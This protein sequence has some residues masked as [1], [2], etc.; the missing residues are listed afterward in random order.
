LLLR[1]AQKRKMREKRQGTMTTVTIVCRHAILI[2][3]FRAL[4]AD[5]D[6]FQFDACPDLDEFRTRDPDQSP[7][8]L[9]IDTQSGIALDA[10]SELIFRTPTSRVLLWTD[11]VAPQ[12]GAQAI[13]IGVCG[14][15]LKDAPVEDYRAC[16]CRVSAGG[17]W[18]DRVLSEQMHLMKAVRLT[19]CERQLVG[20][21][22][23]GLSNK[24]IACHM[25]ITEGT[26]KIYLR[27]LYEQTGTGDRFGL[28][29]FALRNLSIGHPRMAASA[30][31]RNASTGMPFVL[32]EC[33]STE[34]LVQKAHPNCSPQRPV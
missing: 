33:V 32:P 24:E 9:V 6:D 16:L 34:P 15:L 10:V 21:V 22:A 3:G 13:A 23:Q 8:V 27:R 4:V 7:D 19:A 31:P 1:L 18:L 28:A 29:L 5:L 11:D 17:V 20:F 12:F 30:P 14:I 25:Q 26:V 2:G